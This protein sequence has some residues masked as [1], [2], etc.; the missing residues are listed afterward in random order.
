ME[1]SCVGMWGGSTVNVSIDLQLH[2]QYVRTILCNGW[3]NSVWQYQNWVFVCAGK[4][5]EELRPTCESSKIIC[6]TTAAFFSSLLKVPQQR[7]HKSLH[8]EWNGVALSPRK[9]W[10]G[11]DTLLSSRQTEYPCHSTLD[12]EYRQNKGCLLWLQQLWRLLYSSTALLLA[13]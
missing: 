6:C 13:I 12:E 4:Q 2:I 7:S 3:T 5:P 11:D 1:G 9:R 10:Q 8:C